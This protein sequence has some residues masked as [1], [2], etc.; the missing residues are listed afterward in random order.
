MRER[1]T[2]Q[3]A[4]GYGI[5]WS[6]QFQLW[7][8]LILYSSFKF[9]YLL[10][11][12]TFLQC[13]AAIIWDIAEFITLCANKKGIHPGAHIALDFLLFAALITGAVFLIIVDQPIVIYTVYSDS[14]N[15]PADSVL[16]AAGAL[17]VIAGSVQTSANYILL[18]RLTVALITSVF[19]LTLF[20]M[21]CIGVHN[22][23]Q[24]RQPQVIFV[25]QPRT[26][27]GAHATLRLHHQ[28]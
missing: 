20:I 5:T 22:W 15:Y 24:T 8:L 18:Q 25:Q 1:R 7:V 17:A 27:T 6:F 3:E 14:E 19:H 4:A 11:T 2:T 23:R 13:G 28:E 16:L 26:V 12:D 9:A 21:A 10:L